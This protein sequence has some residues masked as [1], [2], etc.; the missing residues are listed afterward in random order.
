M[1]FGHRKGNRYC[2]FQ[3]RIKIITG[4]AHVSE[5]RLVFYIFYIIFHRDDFWINNQ[6][7][8]IN[9]S[10]IV[11]LEIINFSIPASCR[12]PPTQSF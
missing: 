3:N 10:I 12:S 7:K 6:I 9:D 4:C 8:E 11:E 2:V 5:L 1:A